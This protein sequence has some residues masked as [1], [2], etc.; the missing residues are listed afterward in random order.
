MVRGNRKTGRPVQIAVGYHLVGVSWTKE[1]TD[2]DVRIVK[3]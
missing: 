3:L 2:I 1:N